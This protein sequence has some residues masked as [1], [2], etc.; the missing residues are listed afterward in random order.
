M[1]IGLD[2]FRD[3]AELGLGHLLLQP[4]RAPSTPPRT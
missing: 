1:V 2:Q 3:D 4:W